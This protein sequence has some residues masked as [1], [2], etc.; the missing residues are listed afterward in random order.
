[1]HVLFYFS[2]ISVLPFWAAMILF[3]R[4]RLTAKLVASPWII[5]PAVFCYLALAAPHSRELLGVFWLPS[6]ESLAPVM[7]QPWAASMFWAYAGA[8]DLFVGRWIYLDATE[9]GIPHTFVAGPLAVCVLF[10]PVGF[11]LYAGVRVLHR[12]PDP[13]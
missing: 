4:A 7:A 3:P 2:A 1:M 5:L 8:F 12:R 10:G 6:P 11:L 13:R 9:R